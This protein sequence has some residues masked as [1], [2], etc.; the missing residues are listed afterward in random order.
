[1]VLDSLAGIA[2]KAGS[3]FTFG[4]FLPIIGI[5]ILGGVILLLAK[6]YFFD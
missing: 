4:D 3:G 6:K 1:M 5:L 2:P